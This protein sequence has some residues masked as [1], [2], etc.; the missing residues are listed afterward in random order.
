MQPELMFHEHRFRLAALLT[1]VCLQFS[2]FLHAV[3]LILLCFFVGPPTRP[4]AAGPAP[5]P[6]DVVF[7]QCTHEHWGMKPRGIPESARWQFSNAR[8]DVLCCR[9]LSVREREGV[10]L[11]HS[12]SNA[13]LYLLCRHDGVRLAELIKKVICPS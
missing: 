8:G 12:S 5:Q 11:E 4:C 9:A 6:T 7:F 10:H 3:Q 13:H 2:I 1:E